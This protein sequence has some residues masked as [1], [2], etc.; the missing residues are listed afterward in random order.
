[1]ENSE[2]K[3][4]AIYETTNASLA[5][6]LYNLGIKFL[7]AKLLKDPN[8]SKPTVVLRYLDSKLNCRDLEYNYM[9]SS[10]KLHNE[11]YR[12]FLTEIHKTLKRG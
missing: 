1:M 7:E 3:N 5:A 10:E 11:I 6:Y 4:Q 12:Y 9:K 2:F 8:V